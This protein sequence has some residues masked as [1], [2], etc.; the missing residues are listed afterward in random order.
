MILPF[1]ISSS[2]RG[3]TTTDGLWHTNCTSNAVS[4]LGDI[5]RRYPE[6]AIFLALA[7]GN[8]LGKL[9]AGSFTL[10]PVTGTLLAGVVIGQLEIPLGGP[11][12]S[13]FFLM[14]LFAVG[15]G[16]GPQFFR[17]L[18]TD[19]LPQAACAAI[20]CVIAVL[21][22]FGLA[23]LLGYDA[24]MAAG[25][26]SGSQTM[27]AILGVAADTI[28]QLDLPAEQRQAMADHIP[29]AYAVTYLFGTAGVG[30][31]LSTI[32]PRLVGGNLVERCREL[33]LQLGARVAEPGAVAAARRFDV[34]A[35]RLVEEA[36]VHQTVAALESR[37]QGS[38]STVERMRRGE[39]ILEVEPE[40]RLEAG[41]ILAVVGRREGVAECVQWIGPE[42]HDYE[43]MDFTATMLDVVLTNK[44]LAGRTIGELATLDEGRLS[45]GVFLRG[46]LR[47]GQEMPFTVGTALDRGDVL[48]IVGPKRHVERVAADLGYADRPTDATDMLFV[49]AGIVAGGIVGGLSVRVGG[50]SLSLSTSVG[51]LLAGLVFG[52][53]R[54]VNRTF[55]RVPAPALWLLNNIGLTTFIAVVGISSGPAFVSGLRAAGPM[56]FVAGI[57][58]TTVPSIA[59]VLLARYVFRFHPGIALGVVAGAQTTTAA[60]PMIEQAAQSKVPALGFTVPFAVGAILMTMSGMVIVM[61]LG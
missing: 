12:K 37:L 58:A 42:E 6:L 61:L 30:W 53:L 56:L 13:V 51:A 44:A 15:Y 5:F 1:E 55:G 18:K 2:A 7:L 17:G 50:V 47:A 45:R 14:F 16:I 4:F 52:W 33:E 49:A 48:Q 46:L 28:G 43:L 36:L 10:G 54:A 3:E 38:R 60:L 31:L 34:R 25:L 40:M 29:V 26:L 22:V 20:Q 57:V 59:G 39:R 23:R 35:F 19:G 32:G 11:V 41:D 27:S 8:W 21:V 9:R 24:G